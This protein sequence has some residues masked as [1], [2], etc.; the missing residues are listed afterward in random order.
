MSE[1]NVMNIIHV[2][3]QLIQ[4]TDW[5][6]RHGGMLGLKYLLVVRKVRSCI[7]IKF[8]FYSYF[9]TTYVG[10]FVIKI[11]IAPSYCNVHVHVFNFVTFILTYLLEFFLH[12][13]I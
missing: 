10:F 13:R 2:L 5:T 9:S 7:N 6:T 4:H 11:K 8:L 3:I 1:E 12:F